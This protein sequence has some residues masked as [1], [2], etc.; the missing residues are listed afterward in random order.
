MYIICES[1]V[2]KFNLTNNAHTYKWTRDLL[3]KKPDS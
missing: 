2:D 1:T 3:D